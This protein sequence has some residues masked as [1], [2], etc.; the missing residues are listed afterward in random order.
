MAFAPDGLDAGAPASVEGGEGPGDLRRKVAEDGFGGGVD[1]EGGSDEVEVR[2]IGGEAG[3]GEVAVLLEVADAGG[4]GDGEMVVADADP[5]VEPLEG[6][7]E[8]F[9]GFEFDDGELVGAGDGE[10]VEHAAVE[11][12]AGSGEG[13]DFGVDGGGLEVGVEGGEV[14]AEGGVEPALG[15]GAEEGVLC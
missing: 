10:E 6:E 13:G 9:G 14:G 5:V 3:V 12:G 11:I 2:G 4:A 8:V 1:V 7:V 15:L